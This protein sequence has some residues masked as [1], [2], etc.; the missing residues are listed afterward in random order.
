MGVVGLGACC[1][2]GVRVRLGGGGCGRGFEV[3][4]CG[5]VLGRVLVL[6]RFVAIGPGFGCWR[7]VACNRWAFS[8]WVFG[9]FELGLMEDEC[10]GAA[11]FDAVGV[12]GELGD[13][14]ECGG[15]VELGE[16]AC[17]VGGERFELA[18]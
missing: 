16:E 8:R 7:G 18:E 4:V 13:G 5:V 10:R 15:G 17:L 11:A 12:G 6:Y 14:G 3:A 9:G 1:C 2:V